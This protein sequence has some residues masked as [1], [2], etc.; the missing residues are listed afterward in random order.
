MKEK[1]FIKDY[2]LFTSLVVT[3]IGIGLFYGPSFVARLIGEESYLASILMTIVLLLILYM[4]HSILKMNN[5]ADIVT[6]L[7]NTYGKVIGNIISIVYSVSMIVILSMSLRAFADVIK[8]YLLPKTKIEIII[9]VLVFMGVYLVK[10][11]LKNLVYFNEITFPIMFIPVS[12]ILLLNIPNAKIGRLLPVFTH[13][14]I[15]Y[16]QAVMELFFLLSGFCIAFILFPYVKKKENIN[17]IIRRSSLFVGVFYTVTIMFVI[18]TLSASQAANKIFPTITML[19]SI[20]IRS[21]VL[22]R[23]DGIVMAL[24]VLF[25]YTTFTGSYYFSTHIITKVFNIEDIRISSIIYVPI[26]YILA[27]YP[28]S[29]AEL[30]TVKIGPAKIAFGISL[31]VVIFVSYFINL[32]KS[33]GGQKNEV[34]KGSY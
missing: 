16:A 4:I 20:N 25:Y 27:L 32:F 17:R 5:Y 24:W 1:Y 18:A 9:V 13:S 10:G 7:K 22:E 26:I 29:M 12:V 21:G 3:M 8:I 2:G 15:Q 33:K 19:R 30:Y 28:Q 34:K 6:V 11:G 23:W 14:P 31:V